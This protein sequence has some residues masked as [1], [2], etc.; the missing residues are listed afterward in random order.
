MCRNPEDGKEREEPAVL[1]LE[2]EI[3]LDPAHQVDRSLL[4]KLENPYQLDQFEHPGNTAYPNDSNQVADLASRIEH[5]FKWENCN[6][7]NRKPRGKILVKDGGAIF[8]DFEVI[9]VDGRIEDD[10]DVDQEKAIYNTIDRQGCTLK[11]RIQGNLHGRRKAGV[12]Q[13]YGHEEIPI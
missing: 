4:L 11:S 5:P 2:T 8:N 3:F 7:V 6:Q 13:H 9:V 12:Q 1:R 10:E